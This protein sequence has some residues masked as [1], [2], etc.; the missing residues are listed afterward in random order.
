M[1]LSTIL[2]KTMYFLQ[3]DNIITEMRIY[4]LKINIYMYCTKSVH[5]FLIFKY[6]FFLLFSAP[7]RTLGELTVEKLISKQRAKIIKFHFNYRRSI[8]FRRHFNV[9]ESPNQITIHSLTTLS[10]QQDTFSNP[11]QVENPLPKIFNSYRTY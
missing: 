2:T 1:D 11:P 7:E 9:R 3:D 10:E 6:F 8:I 4:I 5:N